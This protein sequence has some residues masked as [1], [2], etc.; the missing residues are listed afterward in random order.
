VTDVADL[1]EGMA[2]PELVDALDAA[3]ASAFIRAHKP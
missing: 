2:L 3:F 1:P